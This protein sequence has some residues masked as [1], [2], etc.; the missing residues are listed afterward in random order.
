MVFSS[1]KLPDGKICFCATSDDCKKRKRYTA[2]CI[3]DTDFRVKRCFYHECQERNDCHK[4]C[5]TSI[6]SWKIPE[7]NENGKCRCLECRKRMDCRDVCKND[8][9]FECLKHRCKCR[10]IVPIPKECQKSSDCLKKCRITRRLQKAGRRSWRIWKIPHCDENGKCRCSKCQE[11]MDCRDIC[12]KDQD[13]EC[14]NGRC[15][16]SIKILTHNECNVNSDC[17]KRCWKQ[18][19]IGSCK[20]GKCVCLTCGE[21]SDCKDPCHI[22][23]RPKYDC[24]G[25]SGT[26]KCSKDCNRNRD[27][28]K[29]CRNK[30]KLGVCK[31]GECICENC[32]RTSDCKKFC[33]DLGRPRYGCDEETGKC[34]CLRKLRVRHFN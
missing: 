16:C 4:R 22:V 33:K 32:V 24:D 19:K 12:Q 26:C 3:Y 14:H 5:K 10:K 15:K 31:K 30:E 18:S 29:R 13:F 21:R 34:K 27:C 8:H 6:N 20:E 9:D 23:G 25:E 17:K 28:K 1:S 2:R 11:R 7:C